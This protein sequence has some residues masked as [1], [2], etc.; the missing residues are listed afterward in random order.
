[1]LECIIRHFN[2]A[3]SSTQYVVDGWLVIATCLFVYVSLF[4]GLSFMF[5][6]VLPQFFFVF[7]V[8]TDS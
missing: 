5:T 3:Y 8:L 2:I 1:M 4:I 7:F 6:F